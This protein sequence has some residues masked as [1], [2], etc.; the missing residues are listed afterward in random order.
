[1]HIVIVPQDSHQ[2]RKK[3]DLSTDAVAFSNCA[4]TLLSLSVISVLGSKAP[5]L[6]HLLTSVLSLFFIS[7]FLL[8]L[9]AL[10]L[11][12]PPCAM[13]FYPN[14]IFDWHY[15]LSVFFAGSFFWLLSCDIMR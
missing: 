15:T 1:M 7:L 14:D 6:C 8:F 3:N 4:D 10:L 13:G 9:L 5:R 2:C 11:S 12:G